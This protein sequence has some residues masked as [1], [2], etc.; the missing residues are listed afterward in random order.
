MSNM[1]AKKTVLEE[2]DLDYVTGGLD[3]HN[4]ESYI[5][6]LGKAILD[7]PEPKAEAK[8]EQERK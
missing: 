2:E 8:A 3:I 4:V 6:T 5:D 1:E 7:R